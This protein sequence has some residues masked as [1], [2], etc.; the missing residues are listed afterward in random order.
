MGKSLE[1]KLPNLGVTNLDNPMNQVP[2]TL[3]FYVSTE[4]FEINKAIY[5]RDVKWMQRVVGLLSY[6]SLKYR[7]DLLYYVNVLAKHTLYPSKDVKSLARQLVKYLWQTRDKTLVGHKSKEEE[8]KIT[9]TSDAAFANN[10]EF[11]S[12][13]GYLLSVN[14]KFITGKSTTA[15]LICVSTTEAELCAI[16][17]SFLILRSIH[18]LLNHISGKF[19]RTVILSDSKPAISNVKKDNYKAFRTNIFGTKAFRLRQE[20]KNNDLEIYYINTLDNTA[21]I[22]TKPLKADK[23]NIFTKNWIVHPEN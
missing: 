1:K 8:N 17:A 23:F 18:V 3:N 16:S 14:D 13:I 20:M 2:G 6:V 11:K 12:Q 22:L 4:D 9:A 5:D 19:F 21:D 7:F 15:S 10:Q